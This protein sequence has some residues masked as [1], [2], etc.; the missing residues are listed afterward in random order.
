MT[1]YIG[2]RHF[3]I[4]G[5]CSPAPTRLHVIYLRCLDGLSALLMAYG[6]WSAFFAIAGVWR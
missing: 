3:V 1:D 2:P 6:A 5:G 4:K